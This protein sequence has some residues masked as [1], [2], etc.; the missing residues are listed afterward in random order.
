MTTTSRRNVLL[1]LTAATAAS[2]VTS[3]SAMAQD[4]AE[5]RFDILFIAKPHFDDPK[6]DNRK[7]V[8]HHLD[9][10]VRYQGEIL[11]FGSMLDNGAYAKVVW[12]DAGDVLEFYNDGKEWGYDHPVTT[13]GWYIMTVLEG[14]VWS[15]GDDYIKIDSPQDCISILRNQ[16]Q[17]D[18]AAGNFGYLDYHS[19]PTEDLIQ[20]MA[21]QA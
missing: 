14:Q 21:D 15:T 3:T 19:N 2:F 17:I 20:A 11:Y 9:A 4:I 1:G 18:F 16:V 6:A 13:P 8:T 7:L 5:G 12:F 10:F